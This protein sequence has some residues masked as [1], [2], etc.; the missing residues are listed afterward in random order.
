[1]TY[2]NVLFIN[3]PIEDFTAYNLYA[4]PLGLLKVG[5][6]LKSLGS[7][8]NYLDFLDGKDISETASLPPE[9]KSDGRH[10]YWQKEI[11]KP[12][13]LKFVK[14]R[15]RRFGASKESILKKL[16]Q[17]DKPDAVFISSGMTYW[18]KTV[19][20]MK[21]SV[22]EIFG[23]VPVFVGGI[24]ATLMPQFFLK[25]GF[26]VTKGAYTDSAIPYNLFSEWLKNLSFFPA[27]LV[28]GCYLNCEYCSS[29]LFYPKMI[30]HDIKEE[31]FELVE[32]K[33]RTGKSDVAFYDDALL[34]KKGSV[35]NEF[36]ELLPKNYFRFHTPN[37]LHLREIDEDCAQML[38]EGGFSELRFGFE[39]V[40]NSYDSKAS[41]QELFE[42][43]KILR[44]CGYSEKK[45]GIYLL[46]GLPGQ[47]V[48]AV[49]ESIN[50]VFEA[51]GRPYLSEFSPVP[52]TTL[53]E[54]HAKESKLD[55]INEPLYQNNTLSSYRSPV[56][57]EEVM[58]MLKSILA[59][60]YVNQ[61]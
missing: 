8:V 38:F 55:F 56:F 17:L 39:T 52:G 25:Q 34:M 35:L 14:R 49:V 22:E 15:F 27:N 45:L 57:T 13:E 1:V 3:P 36:L 32:W 11:P 20:E 23:K 4:V 33:N 12:D 5:G 9:F 51:G 54:K 10:S 18:Y 28:S 29:K 46:C 7:T 16:A 60:G 26:I 43:L 48:S 47:T 19:L 37:G 58:T 2:K 59:K 31:A 61:L 41:V 30:F 42:K 50:I 6:F 53:F 44:K 21:E 40:E 24:A